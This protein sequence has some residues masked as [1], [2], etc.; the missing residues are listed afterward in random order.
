MEKASEAFAWIT[1]VLEELNVPFRVTGGLAARVYGSGRPL[2]DIDIEVPEGELPRIFSAVSGHVVFGPARYRDDEFD[3]DLMTL[4]YCGQEIDLAG[5][6]TDLIHDKTTGKWVGGHGDL[7]RCEECEV[8]GVKTPV[9]TLAELIDYKSRI[10]REVD[11]E[12]LRQM[13]E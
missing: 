1:S 3:L 9:V 4:N 5:C 12:D 11:L 6:G 13:G 10:R 7:S 8:F 2:A